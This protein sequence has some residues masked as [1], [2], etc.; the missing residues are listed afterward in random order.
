M[1][2]RHKRSQA[3][4]TRLARGF[5]VPPRGLRHIKEQN[6]NTQGKTWKISRAQAFSPGKRELSLRSQQ[7]ACGGTCSMGASSLW[8]RIGAAMRATAGRQGG[9]EC[10]AA[11]IDARDQSAPM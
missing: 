9:S 2:A 6:E 11:G 10:A 8:I 1:V 5:V 7:D 4:F 3:R